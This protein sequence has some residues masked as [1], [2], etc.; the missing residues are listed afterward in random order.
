QPAVS[1]ALQRLR[2]TFEDP[3]LVR[4][5][6]GYDLSARA[7]ELLPQLSHL[8]DNVESMITG[9][10]FDPSTSTQT[11]RFYGADPEIA[12]FLPPLFA[13]IRRQAP[14]MTLEARSNPRDPFEALE[15]SEIHFVITTFR[16]STITDQYHGSR[17]SDMELVVMM[18]ADHPLAG[19]PLTMEKY[20][21]ASHGL[22]SLTGRGP[23]LVEQEFTGRRDIQFNYSL[24]LTSFTAA[25]SFCENS[26][27]LFLL[28]KQFTSQLTQGHRLVVREPPPE[29]GREPVDV[30]LFWHERYHRD[31]MCIWV[32]DQL[33]ALFPAA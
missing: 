7:A 26:D 6:S 18:R 20:L 29:L 9:S 28:P 15:S 17:L 11:V 2:D 10:R 8:L 23:S 3:L 33:K 31:P 1:R 30:Y 12:W 16:P 32:R 21:A 22:V 13:R 25:A 14:Q 19:E 4:T 24:R 5:T 27:V